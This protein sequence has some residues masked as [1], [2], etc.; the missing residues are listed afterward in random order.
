MDG[1]KNMKEINNYSYTIVTQVVRPPAA[2]DYLAAWENI[3]GT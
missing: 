2:E 3:R 1:K